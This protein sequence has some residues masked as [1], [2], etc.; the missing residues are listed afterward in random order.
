MSWISDPPASTPSLL[1]LQVLSS[2]LTFEI[3]V[4]RE[5]KLL[6]VQQ[7]NKGYVSGDLLLHWK[8]TF[9]LL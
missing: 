8:E 7:A 2:L 1:G 3:L 5:D 6:S 4:L 9:I